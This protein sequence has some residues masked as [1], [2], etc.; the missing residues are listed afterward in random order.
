MNL[1]YPIAAL[2]ITA[3]LPVAAQCPFTPTIEPSSLVLCPDESSTLT[4]QVY[5]AYQWYKDGNLIPGATGQSLAVEQY[6]DAGSNFTVAATL[7]GCT[8]TSVPVLVD[9]WVFLLPYLIHGGDEPYAIGSFGEPFFCEGDTL[10][11]TMGMPYTQQITWYNNGNPIPGETSSVLTITTNGSYTASGAPQVCPNWVSFVGVEVP[12]VFTP[13]QQPTIVDDGNDQLCAE[14]EGGATQ[15]Y[16][17]GVPVDTGACITPTASGPYTVFVDYGQP[18]QAASEPWIATGVEHVA[19]NRPTLM[20]NPA[21]EQLTITWPN[22]TAYGQGWVLRD[23][24]GRP[25]LGGRTPASGMLTL[26]IRSL[27]DGNYLLAPTDRS[28]KPLQVVV[29]H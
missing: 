19:A 11:L 28:W 15:W 18:C 22:G 16:L 7:E 8:E 23:L 9:G 10:T 25:V 14:P 21:R 29:G 5:E 27:A 20:P 2:L 3:A 26:D 12:P 1:H 6:N 24:L 4:T 17:A 13:N